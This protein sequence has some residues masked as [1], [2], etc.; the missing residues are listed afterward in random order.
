MSKF[1]KLNEEEIKID[2]PQ[3]EIINNQARIIMRNEKQE[4][5]VYFLNRDMIKTVCD[6][7]N[8]VIS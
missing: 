1:K 2:V 8:D 5:F 3:E 4:D 7:K 6:L